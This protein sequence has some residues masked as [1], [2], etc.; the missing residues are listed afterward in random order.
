M[1]LVRAA[2]HFLFVYTL[3]SI[4]GP[5]G[6]ELGVCLFFVQLPINGVF[7]HQENLVSW[8][9][10]VGLIT[11]RVDG[12]AFYISSA[13]TEGCKRI[14]PLLFST[15]FPEHPIRCCACRSGFNVLFHAS[16]LFE[17]A[18]SKIYNTFFCKFDSFYP[19]SLGGG[20]LGNRNSKSSTT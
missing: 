8:K 20:G 4:P 7:I 10:L 15:V 9:C 18:T 13:I 14:S 19:H 6:S 16:S 11:H 5:V 2:G 1:R 17:S 12:R 3:F